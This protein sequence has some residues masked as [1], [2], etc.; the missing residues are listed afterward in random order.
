M[1]ARKRSAPKG[2]G[3][4]ARDK[5]PTA[6][7][8]QD[9]SSPAVVDESVW[10]QLQRVSSADLT[11]G[12]VSA[13]I[14]DADM[15]VIRHLVDL[16]HDLRQKD[17]HFQSIMQSR[18]LA[19]SGLPWDIQA[20]DNDRRRGKKPKR[21]RMTRAQ[22][23]AKRLSDALEKADGF[24]DTLAH[25]TGESVLFGFAFAEVIWEKAEDGLMIPVQFKPIA[26]RRFGYRSSDTALL[27]DPGRT[28]MVDLAGID[29]LAEHVPGKF[30][31]VRRRMNGDVQT[32][33]G[34]AR[35]LVW[36]CMF[37]TWGLKDWLKFAEMAWKPWRRAKYAK[38]A[39]KEDKNLAVDI[40]RRMTSSGVAVHPDT[41]EVMI[42]WPKNAI[43]SGNGGGSHKELAEHLGME[44][45]KAV[46]GATLTV[47]AGSKGARSLGDVHKD[48]K[49][50]I[51][52][53]DVLNVAAGVQLG[54]VEPFFAMNY[55]KTVD[56]SR[57]IFQTEDPV[58]LLAFA[59]A[60]QAL[61]DAGLERVPAAWV[62]DQAGMPEAEEGEEVLGETADSNPTDPTAPK[63]PNG[64]DGQQQDSGD[65]QPADE[66]A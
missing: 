3:S 34:L 4:D 53:A 56:V 25:L 38:K 18:E 45:S 55:G 52:D 30:V 15:G 49:Q 66:A 29:L 35:L 41:V 9:A 23:A 17:G 2:R 62:R 8:A 28:G 44:M 7:D 64:G 51:R 54:V 63:D 42:D 13:Y 10:D 57:F 22:K 48:V 59:Q 1:A 26:C 16:C 20:P 14:R 65:G 61:R 21:P 12:R 11:P 37:R 40:M 50:A 39:E 46:L 33:E 47:E 60:I 27:F 31:Y 6:R 5:A 36:L 58:D 32:R 24:T 43:G 19:V